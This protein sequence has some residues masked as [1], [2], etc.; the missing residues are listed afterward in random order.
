MRLPVIQGVIRRR[1]LMNFRVDPDV[2]RRQL[3]R[4][5]EPKLLH[6]SAVAG[7]CLIR[8]EELRPRLAPAVIGIASDNAA[9]RIAVTWLDEAGTEREG[10]YIPR[11]DTSS[12]FNHLAGGRVFPGEHERARFRVDDDGDRIQ[13]AM[14]SLDGT[15]QV[16]I[17]AHSASGLPPTSRFTTLAEASRFFEQGDIGFSP[18]AN[19]GDLDAICLRTRSWRVDPLAVEDVYSSYFGD[20]RRFPPG[21]VE[22]DCALIMRDVPHEWHNADASSAGRVPSRA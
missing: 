18:K 20:E 8:L 21:S 14:Q 7:I 3:P 17:R 13:L 12:I 4:P 19:R 9:H 11:R 5:F 16:A 1:V 22:F 2:I 10:V 6:G 15:V